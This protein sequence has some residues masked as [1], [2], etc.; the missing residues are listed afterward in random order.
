[1]YW[2]KAL[3]NQLL[4]NG[5]SSS[6]VDI[7]QHCLRGNM[8]LF[9]L[10]ICEHY[11]NFFAYVIFAISLTSSVAAIKYRLYTCPPFRSPFLIDILLKIIIVASWWDISHL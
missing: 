3:G 5:Q 11:L 7:W 6:A 10:A 2:P 4:Y 1:M 9:Y 8:V